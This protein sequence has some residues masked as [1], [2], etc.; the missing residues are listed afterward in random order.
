MILPILISVS[1]APGSY[2]FCALAALARDA[3]TSTASAADLAWRKILR[4]K[5]L[6]FEIWA[7]I[8]VLPDVLAEA[9][10]VS[11]VGQLV[12]RRIECRRSMH[13]RDEVASGAVAD[14]FRG[15]KEVSSKVS[16]SGVAR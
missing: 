13:D 5:T 11:W 12:S 7:R 9:R 15:A 8:I 3:A 10:A 14:I 16:G 6:R 4:F 1:V 2:F